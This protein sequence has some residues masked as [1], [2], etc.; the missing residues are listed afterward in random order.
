MFAGGVTCA[1]G[2]VNYTGVSDEESD[3]GGGG[4]HYGKVG[5]GRS[6]RTGGQRLGAHDTSSPVACRFG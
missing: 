2:D 5:G 1:G 6:A 4:H 3:E